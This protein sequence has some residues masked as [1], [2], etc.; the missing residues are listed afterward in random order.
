MDYKSLNVSIDLKTG[1][2]YHG[3]LLPYTLAKKYNMIAVYR[4]FISI[5]GNSDP[6]IESSVGI[7]ENLENVKKALDNYIDG[8]KTKITCMKIKWS[9]KKSEYSMTINITVR[10]INEKKIY[11]SNLTN[12]S[13]SQLVDIIA[14]C[15]L[16]GMTADFK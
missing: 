10:C 3:C 11:T 4:T 12:L 9:S 14:Y 13:D 2:Q 15:V 8:W 6:Y 16:K 5:T 1:V 7:H